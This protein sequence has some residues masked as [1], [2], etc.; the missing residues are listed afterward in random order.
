MLNETWLRPNSPY[1]LNM[2][3]YLLH[4]INR[5]STNKKAKRGSGGLICYHRKEITDGIEFI[6]SPEHTD[7][8]WVKLD[9]CFFGFQKDI[10]ICSVYVTPESSTHNSSRDNVWHLLQTEIA[11]LST[12][13]DIMLTGDF[14]ARTGTQRDYVYHDSSVAEHYIPLPPDYQ[15]DKEKMRA[16]QDVVINNYGRELLDL[17]I[18]SRL[19]IV[20]GRHDQDSLG[21]FTC[22]TP[23]GNS[24]VD[25][26]IVS[27]ELMPSIARF[28]IDALSPLSD[29]CPLSL[30]L[31]TNPH[32]PFQLSN[33]LKGSKDLLDEYLERN[34]ITDDSYTSTTPKPRVRWNKDLE[35]VLQQEFADNGFI[36]K[37]C[38]LRMQVDNTQVDHSVSKFVRLLQDTI[39]KCA[40]VKYPVNK[41]N[42]NPFPRNSWFDKECKAMKSSVNRLAKKMKKNPNSVRIRREFWNERKH[43]KRLIRK[44]KRA[45]VSVFHQNLQ[46]FRSKDPRTFW[47]YIA[48]ASERGDSEHIPISINDMTDHFRDLCSGPTQPPQREEV[49]LTHNFNELTDAPID[50][51]E[52]LRAIKKQK[53]NKAPGQDGL[54]P[55]LFKLF[56]GR[57]VNHLT[58]LFNKVLSTGIYPKT[59]SVGNIKPIHKKGDKTNPNNYRGITLLD[60][61]GALFTS[62]LCERI[63][64]WAEEEG[65]VSEAQ[66]GFRKNRRTTDAIFILN[67]AIQ[68][69]KKRGKQLYTCFVDFSKAFD[70][71]DHR[72]LW[73]KLAS[74][75]L[76]S[77]M[78]NILQSMYGQASSRVT[79]NSDT[80][81]EFLYRKG[82]RQGCNLSPLLFSLFIHDLEKY[83]VENNSGSIEINSTNLHLLLFADDLVL[84]A[85]TPAGLQKSIQILGDYCS[86]WNLRIN[87]EKT[88]V[89]EFRFQRRKD[90]SPPYSLHNQIIEV[91]KSYRYLGIILTSNGGLKTAVDTL[92][93]Q[94]QKSLFCL[95]KKASKLQYPNP[96]LLSHLF[97]ALVRPVLEYG[98]ETWGYIKAEEIEKVHRKFIKFALGLPS[99]A[100]NLAV[101]GEIGRTPL[102]VRRNVLMVKYWLRL[103]TDREISPY[104]SEAY[105]ESLSDSPW[106]VHIKKV[107]ERAGFAEIWLNPQI[108]DQRAVINNLQQRLQDQYTQ[109]WQSELSNTTGKL[110]LYKLFKRNLAPEAYLT[111]PSYLRI[112][113]CKLRVSAHA[114]RI[115]T[116]RYAMPSPIPADQR[117]CWVCNNTEI[118]DEPHFMFSCKLYEELPER[119]SLLK[120]C[121]AMNHSFLHLSTLD[122]FLFVWSV[123]DKKLLHLL[124]LFIYKASKHRSAQFQG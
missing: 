106:A 14:N 120:Y 48:K 62:V 2:K 43:Y 64:T 22:F 42:T 23:R 50:E 102:D 65:R 44:K 45:A 30:D 122:K 78:L 20:N 58:L 35:Q 55:A 118:E 92:A 16:S 1:N 74:Y 46:S 6:N 49:T 116:G 123:N 95:L 40:T 37:L 52:I 111:L 76:S 21:G 17:C 10:Y 73:S 3:D 99:S 119:S 36:D 77:T 94:G 12:K 41:R 91:T 72:L 5:P 81:E 29:H 90:P 84:L 80:S 86:K 4:I 82:V 79:L 39:Q 93:K 101:Y 54:P 26:S 75:G 66:F 32:S 27:P 121:C 104:L 110:R 25:Y 68:S 60:V 53:S 63:S 9:K 67:T 103:A 47:K 19:R 88:K 124:G 18:S 51:E 69:R 31:K 33:L 38:T 115:E 11:D 97:D 89:M 96:L 109:S 59:W 100:A 61:M 107:L 83:L 105:L 57:L 56:D 113:I 112:P 98:S 108:V 15:T 71:V 8:L 85:D 28:N 7:R 34:D 117:T 114:L 70:T 24:V 13:G 87:M